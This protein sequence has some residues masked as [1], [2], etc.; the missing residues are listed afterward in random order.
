MERSERESLN[1]RMRHGD[2][3]ETNNKQ[4]QGT[5][6]FSVDVFVSVHMLQVCGRIKHVVVLV[7]ML[8]VITSLVVNCSHIFTF[9][10]YVNP[11][12]IL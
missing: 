11:L 2:D 3:D 8:R 6:E 10:L 5:H 7:A 9:H 4:A 12:Q 1:V